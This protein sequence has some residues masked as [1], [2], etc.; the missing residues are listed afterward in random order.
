MSALQQ[1]FLAQHLGIQRQFLAGRELAGLAV[2]Q[3]QAEGKFTLSET[4]SECRHK[5]P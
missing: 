1:P 4:D 3:V 2:G 5:V